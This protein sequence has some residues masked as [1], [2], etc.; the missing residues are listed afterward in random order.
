MVWGSSRMMSS[1]QC[2]KLEPFKQF[3]KSNLSQVFEIEGLFRGTLI[4]AQRYPCD[5]HGPMLLRVLD[6]YRT[7]ECE[8]WVHY[9]GP[10]R[11]WAMFQRNYSTL[12]I[13]D[14][15]VSSSI[16]PT[17]REFENN[18]LSLRMGKAQV[19]CITCF[20][21]RVENASLKQKLLAAEG[22]GGATT[23]ESGAT[24]A[25]AKPLIR[26]WFDTHYHREGGGIGYSRKQ[27]REELSAYLSSSFGFRRE[28]TPLC[29]LWSWFVKEVIA[30]ESRQYRPFRVWKKM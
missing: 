26:A 24:E 9:T 12:S 13:L 16:I 28:L 8:W 21:L 20:D 15:V 14:H 1:T 27:L 22:A 19:Y 2:R 23:H 29:S 10:K 3:L 18:Q 30:D 7:R 11:A 5:E 4:D 6:H 17:L 25:N